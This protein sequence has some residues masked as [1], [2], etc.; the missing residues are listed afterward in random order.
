MEGLIG[1]IC[2]RVSFNH[3]RH[4]SF[5]FLIC[6]TL[7]T[8]VKLVLVFINQ[9]YFLNSIC[10]AS[11][12][13]LSFIYCCFLSFRLVETY[14]TSHTVCPRH[15]HFPRRA[16]FKY[17]C[18]SEVIPYIKDASVGRAPV[19]APLSGH[20]PDL[21]LVIVCRLQVRLMLSRC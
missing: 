5:H 17:F 2:K 12:Y 18:H 4:T 21:S 3:L 15:V 7:H 13:N 14:S 19:S 11:C 6:R 16:L 1:Q 10:R 20:F 8:L 9:Y